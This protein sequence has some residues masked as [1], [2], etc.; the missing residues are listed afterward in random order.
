MQQPN[1]RSGWKMG[2]IA[3]CAVLGGFVLSFLAMVILWS[4]IPWLIQMIMFLPFLLLSFAI[5]KWSNE[6]LSMCALILLGAAPLGVLMLQFRDTTGSHLLPVLVVLS[7][8]IGISAGCYLG[9]LR[10]TV[11]SS[12]SA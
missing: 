8:I 4:G 9:K 5:F 6:S 12:K 10:G 11:I 3:V 2:L 7:W 1:R